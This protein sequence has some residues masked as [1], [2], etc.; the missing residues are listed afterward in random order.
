MPTSSA[1]F[2]LAQTWV[3]S[4][5]TQEV[6]DE[7]VDRLLPES[8]EQPTA[9]NSAIEESLREQLAI[10]VLNRPSSMSVEGVSI[11]YAANIVALR[12]QLKRFLTSAIGSG[13]AQVSQSHRHSTR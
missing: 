3:G 6:F 1:E 11:S 4:K 7:R 9:I 5:E 13:R 10:M 2:R 12:E 8:G